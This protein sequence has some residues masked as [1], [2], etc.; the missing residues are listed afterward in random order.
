M[1]TIDTSFIEKWCFLF[2]RKDL[3]FY[4]IKKGV[5]GDEIPCRL[6]EGAQTAL[7]SSKET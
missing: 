5:V 3:L 1:L 6:Q 4:Q 7:L 2:D